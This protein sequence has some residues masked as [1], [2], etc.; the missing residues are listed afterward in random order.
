MIALYDTVD[1]NHLPEPTRPW[2]VRGILAGNCVDRVKNTK[3]I[4]LVAHRNSDNC[5]AD[6]D[7]PWQRHGEGRPLADLAG[8]T[9]AALHR[10]R[11]MFDDR[12]PQASAA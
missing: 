1:T 5:L 3:R 4:R 9:H 7:G 8:G 10:M 6:R 2:T 11:E 12:Q